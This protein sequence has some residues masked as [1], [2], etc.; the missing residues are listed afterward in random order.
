MTLT[1]RLVRSAQRT[2]LRGLCASRPLH[3]RPEHAAAHAEAL[4]LLGSRGFDLASLHAQPIVWGD[5][6]SFQHVNNVRYVR[7]LESG[8]IVWMQSVGRAAGGAERAQAMLAGRGV[9]L[10]LKS[11]DVQFRRPVTYPDTLLIAHKAHNLKPTQLNLAAVAYS[12]AQRRVV[13]ESDCV[14]VW[15]NYDTL[16]KS[17][18]PP[19]LAAVIQK[20]SG[21][22]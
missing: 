10:I 22:H 19:D 2:S 14:C 12:Y 11:I 16:S 7:F 8:R 9:S 4:E 21:E 1:T 5:L 18:V 3:T 6:D 13:T 20:Q 15:Y 17:E